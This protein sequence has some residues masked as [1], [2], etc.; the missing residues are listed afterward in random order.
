MSHIFISYS[1]KDIALA[2]RIVTA[3]AENELDTWVDWK[4]I[5]KGED[6]LQQ[7]YRGIEEADA[8]L[9]LVSEDS[10]VSEPCNAEIAHAVKNG[11]RIL[12]VFITNAENKDVYNVT[13]RF[14]D[15]ETKNEIN[16]R[17][18]IFCRDE[19]DNFTQAIAEIHETIHTDYEWLQYHR[20]LQVKA[21]AWQAIQDKSRLLRGKELAEAEE[22]LTETHEH[23]LPTELQRNYVLN[24]RRNEDAQRRR[25]TISFGLG[26]VIVALLAV[27]AWGQR[28]TAINEANAK[29][30][31]LV[32]EESARSTAQAEKSRAETQRNIALARHL[33]TQAELIFENSNLEQPLAV[34]LAV[35]AMKLY[36]HI[37]ATQIL[38]SMN[39]AQSILSITLDED[40]ASAAMTPN[41]KYLITGGSDGVIRVWDVTS[42]A[43]V[44]HMLH[45]D[46]IIALTISSN[47]N[48]VASTSLD[49]TLRVWNL[50]DGTEYLKIST[51]GRAQLII[52]SPDN[53]YLAF[54]KCNKFSVPFCEESLVQ[55]LN[56]NNA[57]KISSVM[58]RGTISSVRFSQDSKYLVSENSLE[59]K[60]LDIAT[61]TD[62]LVTLD[63]NKQF[64]P[65]TNSSVDGR[66]EI[67][68]ISN[69]AAQLW[70]T[71]TRKEVL[72]ITHESELTSIAFSPDRNFIV[73]TACTQRNYVF[74]AQ[75]EIKI[76]DIENSLYHP[77]IEEDSDNA[78][79]ITFSDDGIYAASVECKLDSLNNLCLRSLVRFWDTA[80]NQEKARQTYYGSVKALAVSSDSRYIFS[81]GCDQWDENFICTKGVVHIWDT[82]SDDGITTLELGEYVTNLSVS[83]DNHILVAAGCKNY[84]RQ[85]QY[86]TGNTLG[87][88]KVGS[89]EK[90]EEIEGLSARVISFSPDGKYFVSKEI[91]DDKEIIQV[92]DTTNLAIMKKLSYDDYVTKTE[93][94]LNNTLLFT[95]SD[96]ELD[97][98]DTKSWDR[99]TTIRHA[100]KVDVAAFSDDNKS[101]VTVGC[102]SEEIVF[103]SKYK[104][105]LWNAETGKEIAHTY[106]TDSVNQVLF[107]SEKRL[108]LYGS[109]DGSVTV[110]DFDTNEKITQ[111]NYGDGRILQISF[112]SDKR[113]VIS[114]SSN[115]SY[116]TWL[117]RPEDLI[118]DAC[119][120]LNRNL[121]LV[122]WEQYIGASLSYEATCPNL[123]IPK[124]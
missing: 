52:F 118:A 47:G 65:L 43:E 100:Y 89:W 25:L 112:S 63:N 18:F 29:A 41:N 114:V 53:L 98:W 56:A 60:E 14:I 40:I 105:V 15:K 20:S 71:E 80:N 117:Y 68:N 74:C 97:V 115:K 34:L 108:L 45:D 104:I 44:F 62:V 35:Q 58:H 31:A 107:T 78:N 76:W 13:D 94:S 123:R 82:Q 66:Y 21:L 10:V 17:N 37:E 3:L 75:S 111:M 87:I 16:R 55:V 72:R 124:E 83:P 122:E 4:S 92:M 9:F 23:A 67:L 95:L 12:P 73:S 50:K 6:W 27:F 121:T 7:I 49:E 5:P 22:R 51:E 102:D 42:G 96:K 77:K 33:S 103:C 106:H 61:G 81:G 90:L 84:N 36:P 26:L 113:Y 91:K 101:I 28:N 38:Q 85:T 109:A 99:V 120:R 46:A 32:N 19:K 48:Y 86:C 116:R 1:R 2:Q 59:I 93:F 119:T 8:F 70:D 88:W 79:I 39:L 64:E 69:S 57:E 54:S 110:W 30:T 11:K 24:S